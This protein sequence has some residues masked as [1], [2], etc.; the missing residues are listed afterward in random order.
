VKPF[1][2]THSLSFEIQPQ[3]NADEKPHLELAIQP[4]RCISSV[5]RY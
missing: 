1:G 3:I 2:S 4:L 5:K